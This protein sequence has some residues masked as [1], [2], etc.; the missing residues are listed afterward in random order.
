[1]DTRLAILGFELEEVARLIALMEAQGLDEIAYQEG[2]RSIRI[3]GPRSPKAARLPARTAIEAAPPAQRAIAPPKRDRKRDKGNEA[4]PADQITL[5]S[6]MV[7]VF[8]RSSQPGT[9]FFVEVGQT[10]ALKQPIG[11]IEAMKVFSVIEAEHAGVVVAIPAQDGK[12]VQA[13]EALVI[14]RK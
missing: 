2:D 10:V 8:Y 11:M 13:G 4:P 1:M 9:P 3:R 6:P 14:L 7:G 5:T 12:L